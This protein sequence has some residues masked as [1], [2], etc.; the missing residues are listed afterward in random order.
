MKNILG[1]FSIAALVFFGSTGAQAD[2]TIAPGGSVSGITVLGT[3]SIYDVFGHAG[4][5]GGDY[6]PDTPAIR[7]SFGAGAGNV[8]TFSASGLVSCCSDAPNLPPDGGGSGMSIG[9]A[10]GLSSLSG[11]GNIPLVG[12]FTTDSDPFGSAAPSAL[13]FDKFAPASLAPVLNQVFYIGDGRSGYNNGA[14][15]VLTFGAPSNATRLYIGV[16]DA[17]SFS[18]TTGYYNDNHGSFTVNVSLAPVPEP[19][20]YAMLLAGLG[21]LGLAARRKRKTA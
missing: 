11:N 8:F 1:Y 3:A 6:G 10:N 14:G 21:F 4:N 20:T 15:T 2:Y 17:Y 9:G 16:I 18:A 12:V 13:S 19:E 5:P 7:L